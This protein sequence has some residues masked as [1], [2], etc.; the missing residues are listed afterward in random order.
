MKLS[1]SLTSPV[2]IGDR[3]EAPNFLPTRVIFGERDLARNVYLAFLFP[4]LLLFRCDRF[5]AESAAILNDVLKISKE[6]RV[7]VEVDFSVPIVP[8][9]IEQKIFLVQ[10]F[11]DFTRLILLAVRDGLSKVLKDDDT[12][13][14]RCGHPYKRVVVGII[15]ILDVPFRNLV[16]PGVLDVVTQLIIIAHVGVQLR[17]AALRPSLLQIFLSICLCRQL[18]KD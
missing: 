17:T 10:Q 4:H 11:F 5:G 2:I 9:R 7:S 8:L 1:R 13:T 14:D 6:C 3:M 15:F 12:M 16:L 18:L